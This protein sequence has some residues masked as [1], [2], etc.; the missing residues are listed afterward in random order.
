MKLTELFKRPASL[1]N[2]LLEIWE[3]SVRETHL[4]LPES[5]IQNIKQNF[6][7]GALKNITHLIIAQDD[8]RPIAFIG[9]EGQKLEML[10][11]TPEYRGK[12]V[13]RKMIEYAIK[14]FSINEL[15]V[16]EQNPQAKEFYE[17]LGFKVYKRSE[18]DEQG[19]PYPILYMKLLNS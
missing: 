13:G 1:I 18:I 6:L 12:G 5:E 15:T 2:I 7:P 10:F 8:E 14:H 4:F 3:K 11:V 19:N 9:I 17:H 16:N